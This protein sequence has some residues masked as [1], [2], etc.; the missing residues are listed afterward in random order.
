MRLPMVIGACC[1][2][3]A[4]VLAFVPVQFTARS[5]P[6][7]ARSSPPEE[8]VA[9]PARPLSLLFIHHSVGDQLLA[10]PAVD[11]A[12]GKSPNGGG[13]RRL[14]EG[15][16]Y[17]V[18]TATYGSALGEHT[19]LFDWPEKFGPQMERVLT[20]ADGT[21]ALPAGEHHDVVMFKSCFPNS[22]LV[23]RGTAPG[24]PKGPA[25][26]VEN[27]RAALSA[28]LPEMK[29]Q[30]STLFVYLTLPPLA[31][32]TYPQ[33]LGAWLADAVRGKTRASLL[34]EQGSLDRELDDWVMSPDGWLKGYEGKN[35]VA[36]DYYDML[37]G[38]ESNL[39][40]FPN[41]GGVDSHPTSE[42]QKAAARRIFAQLNAA[43]K[44]AGL[45]PSLAHAEA[46]RTP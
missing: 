8:N 2:L 18:H 13:F 11:N 31:P 25:L 12:K 3:A 22:R 30:P 16:G 37:T 32:R 9:P 14:L 33:R 27:A 7:R 17:K 1:A 21:N 20:T 42:G 40:A 39:L 34:G 10:E 35:V 6:T 24:N 15:A 44:R 5:T 26:T 43:V 45:V 19:D 46:L 36:I 28:L 23:G 38:G 4:I 41:G 29:K